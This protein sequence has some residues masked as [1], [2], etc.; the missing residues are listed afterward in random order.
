MAKTKTCRG[1]YQPFIGR[2]GA[3]TCS[4]RC[5]KRLQR[6]RQLLVKEVGWTTTPTAANSSLQRGLLGL[7]VILGGMFA[8]IAMPAQATAIAKGYIAYDA[9][10]QK[11]M[12]VKLRSAGN[13]G[14]PLVE[15]ARY[16]DADKVIGIVVNLTDG[17]ATEAPAGSQVFVEQSGSAQALVSDLNGVVKKGDLLT[18]SSLS[19][20]LM[21]SADRSVATVGTALEESTT[22]LGEL[23]AVKDAS[24]NSLNTKVSLINI[25]VNIQPPS[26]KLVTENSNNILTKLSNGLVGHQV[27]G[28]RVLAALAIFST[29]LVIEGEIIYGTI[30]SSITAI[31]RNPLARSSIGRQSLKGVSVGIIVLIVGTASIWA[32]LWA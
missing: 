14:Q 31:G 29:L 4:A 8:S 18:M 13:G 20:V 6:A 15:R 24:G 28:L 10:L 2:R 17:L 3:K 19:G 1:C 9:N 22:A 32:L 25:N 16:E 5:R 21:R 30:T 11:G 27:S 23:I 26:P 7:A 12:V